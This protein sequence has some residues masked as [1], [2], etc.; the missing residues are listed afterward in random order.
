MLSP[1]YAL[2]A[3]VICLLVALVTPAHADEAEAFSE[4]TLREAHVGTDG[5]ALIALFRKYTLTA[6][7]RRQISALIRQ[8][9][10]DDYQVREHASEQLLEFGPSAAPLLRVAVTSPA[11]EVSR[12]ARRCLARLEPLPAD[13]LA[14][15]ARLLADRPP[16]GAVEALLA[17]LPDADDEQITSEIQATLAAFAFLHDQP[18]RVLVGAL[19][20]HQARRRSAAA[21]AL[22][23]AGGRRALGLVRPLLHD[24]DPPVRLRV[25][26]HL[27]DSREPDAIPVLIALT[28]AAPEL[29]NQADAYLRDL[30]GSGAPT[31]TP[32]TTKASRDKARTAWEQWWRG[33][34]PAT[35]VEQI[36]RGTP[37]DASSARATALI[38][39]LGDDDFTVRERASEALLSMGPV[40]VPLLKKATR[41]TDAEVAHRAAACL[42]RL[43]QQATVM[44]SASTVRLLALTRPGGAAQALL[45]YLPYAAEGPGVD[46]VQNALCVLA[47]HDG[48]VDEAI[49]RALTD[50]SALRRRVAG[51]ALARSGQGVA[52]ELDRLLTD[53]DPEVRLEVALALAEQK[54]ARAVPTLIALL[55]ELPAGQVW[56]ADDLLRRL[57]GPEAPTLAPGDSAAERQRCR[58]AWLAW[59]NKFSAHPD[60]SRLD[61]PAGVVGRLIVVC[62]DG[63]NGSGRVWELG[64]DHKPRWEIVKDLRGPIDAVMV[65]ANRV[66][67]AEYQGFVTE[68]DTHGK[69][70]WEQRITGNPIACQRLPNGNTFVA[71][72]SNMM[73]LTPAGKQV[74]NHPAQGGNL[75]CAS[76][77]RDG[78]IVYLGMNGTLHEM[79]RGGREIRSFPVNA[80]GANYEWRT[81]AV[82]PNGHY[83]VPRQSNGKVFEYDH[84]G[85]VVWRGTGPTPY[86]AVRLGNGH[87]LTVSMNTNVLAEVSRTGKIVWQETLKGRPFKIRWR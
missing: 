73:E 76:V 4:A 20:D 52:P 60:M 58:T 33:L 56:Q 81:F 28:G 79:D 13:V 71:T 57:A 64:P 54:V 16:A 5:P 3:L 48:H 2:S 11:L 24:S 43:E 29:A 32:G 22:W 55:G 15:A 87:L 18:D 59:W 44:I 80:E 27:A 72:M 46:E 36:R 86:S 68:R 14:A 42:A 47:Y 53:S 69:V 51:V 77:L 67:V 37:D 25:A 78:H 1:R 35:L 61:R 66:L 50:S 19:R 65:G 23:Q 10:D 7:E 40:A 12:R 34:R 49:V 39:Q 31:A 26:E 8:L 82:L 17:Y 74:Y 85:K 62:Y 45:A 6:A 41:N 9:N 30:A 63:Y 84:T 83:L 75:T 38:E 70:L 21:E